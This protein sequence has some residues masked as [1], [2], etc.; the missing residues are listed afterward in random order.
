MPQTD[1]E[2][3]DRAQ[4]EREVA[5]KVRNR[6]PQSDDVTDLPKA[7]TQTVQKRMGERGEYE[8]SKIGFMKTDKGQRIKG[9]YPPTKIYYH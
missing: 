3:F 6:S 5:S 2:N 1:D 8:S 9:S 4:Q 7:F